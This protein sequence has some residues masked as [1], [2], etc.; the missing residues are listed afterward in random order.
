MNNLKIVV[1]PFLQPQKPHNVI[2]CWASKRMADMAI[3]SSLTFGSNCSGYTKQDRLNF[4]MQVGQQ[5]NFYYEQTQAN[6]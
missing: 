5:T 4:K 6:H 2:V 3:F 1:L